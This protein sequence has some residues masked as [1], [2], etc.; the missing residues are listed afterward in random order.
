MRRAVAYTIAALDAAAAI[1][2]DRTD[3]DRAFFTEEKKKRLAVS[4]ALATADNNLTAFELGTGLINQVKV[5][6]GDAVL[7][8]CIG[9]S[10]A[11]TKLEL[12]NTPGLGAQHVFGNRTD[13]LMRQP[14]RLEPSAVREAAERL[15][16]IHDFPGKE[17]MKHIARLIV[18]VLN[19][20][21]NQDIEQE[22][23]SEVIQ[24]CSR[25]PLPG[26]DK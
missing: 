8:R 23:R 10:A 26:T 20:V 3:E 19:N 2:V 21:D 18:R 4:E 12:R 25:F 9:A 14:L 22:V 11:R 24:I 1:D 13:D 17:E 6:L 5:T 7:D 16:D 15:D